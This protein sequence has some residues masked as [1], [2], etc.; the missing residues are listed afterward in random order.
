[1]ARVGMDEKATT[2]A[3]H[4]YPEASAVYS[5]IGLVEILKAGV[6]WGRQERAAS[7]EIAKY[8]GKFSLHVRKAWG[9][10]PPEGFGK[11]TIAIRL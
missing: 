8:E 5:D 9:P 11:A 10:F 1:M 6:D 7:R 2:D 4:C 3:C